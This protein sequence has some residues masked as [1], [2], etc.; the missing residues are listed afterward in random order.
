ME[1]GF[2]GRFSFD[3]A[4]I[5]ADGA[6]HVAGIGLG[7]VGVAL[8]FAAT[9]QGVGAAEVGSLAIYA[10]SLLA[11]L[12]ISAIYNLWPPSPTKW[13]LRKFDHSAIYLLIAGTYTP[14]VMQMPRGLESAL[15]LAGI[16]TVSLVGMAL[17]ILLPGRFDRL[18]ILL[19]LLLGWSGLL[20]YEQLL[21]LPATT[22]A[23]IVA[24]G[25]LYTAGVV[26]H[27]WQS[28]RFQNAIWHAFVLVAAAC[29]YGA[30]FDCVILARQLHA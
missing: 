17:K 28:L 4:E 11:V 29:H 2:R 10:F 9:L 19:Y 25:L 27:L 30:V 22:L 7:I 8:L 20:I 21:T 5:L 6:V 24:G 14:F 26:F 18:S 13:H 16:W 23:L 15:L 12:I 3:L 1:K